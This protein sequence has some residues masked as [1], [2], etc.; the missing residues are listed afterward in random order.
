VKMLQVLLVDDD[1][2]ILLLHGYLVAQAGL[3]A[4]RHEFEHGQA[5][6][7]YLDSQSDPEARYLVLLDINMPILN[8]WGFLEAL[9][10]RHFREQV[11][12]A[13]VTSSINSEDRL[14]AS[15]YEQIVSY[16]VKPIS[17]QVLLELKALS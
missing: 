10:T 16:L 14:K 6:L 17:P 3:G 4:E 8:G 15:D 9:Q 7:D 1:P 13:M 12:V 2:T 11:Q 5:A